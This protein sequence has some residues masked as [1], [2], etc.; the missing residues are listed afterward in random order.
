MRVS[1]KSVL[2]AGLAAGAIAYSA[3]A[4]PL[5]LSST[6]NANPGLV[7]QTGGPYQLTDPATPYDFT[8]Q[9]YATL[10]SIDSISVTLGVN[11][12]DTGVGE[13]DRD[14]LTLGLDGINTGLKLNDF[15]NGQIVTQTLTQL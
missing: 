10:T 3:S 5:S 14:D 9:P 11:D 8:A 1:L 13:F 12:G 4:A 7:P 15:L 2:A 6:V